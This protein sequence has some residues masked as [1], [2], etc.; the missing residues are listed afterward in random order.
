M[1]RMMTG[2]L[3]FLPPCSGSMVNKAIFQQ[4]LIQVKSNPYLALSYLPYLPILP[5][6]ETGFET[7]LVCGLW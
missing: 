4:D 5:G 7:G 1:L 3:L 6:P 2:M